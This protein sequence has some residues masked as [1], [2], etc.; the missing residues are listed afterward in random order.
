MVAPKHAVAYL[1][2]IILSTM[3]VHVAGQNLTTYLLTKYA[4][5]Y[6]NVT[7]QPA[8]FHKVLNGTV[9]P[10]QV[11]YFFEQVGD[12]SKKSF[13]AL[14]LI[15]LPGHYLW[16]RFHSPLWQHSQSTD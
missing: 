6:H 8:F 13:L 4:D 7:T 1:Q 3:A 10:E 12:I 15:L 16:S 11:A 14:I 9:A 5:V 2:Q